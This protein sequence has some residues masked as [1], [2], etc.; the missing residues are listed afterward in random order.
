MNILVVR[1]TD[2]FKFIENQIISG[3]GMVVFIIFQRLFDVVLINIILLKLFNNFILH[4]IRFILRS[5]FSIGLFDL[6]ISR[7]ILNLVY[8]ISFLRIRV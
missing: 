8:G 6:F 7:M 1:V 4:G 2:F 5:Y 3:S